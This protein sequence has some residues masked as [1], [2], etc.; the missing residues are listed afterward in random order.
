MD[1][2]TKD[3]YQKIQD[4]EILIDTYEDRIGTYLMQ[5]TGK[6]M[7]VAQNKEL[8]KFLHTIGDFERL[9]DRKRR[10]SCMRKSLLFRKKRSMKWSF[11]KKRFRKSWI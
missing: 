5:L 4:K 11:W 10:K 3:K 6:E 9:G 7:T 2:Y 8:T 1:G